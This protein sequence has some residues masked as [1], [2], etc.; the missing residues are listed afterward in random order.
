MAASVNFYLNENFSGDL[1]L[2]L[3]FPVLQNVEGISRAVFYH[4]MNF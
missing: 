3:H 2:F 4:I 1:D